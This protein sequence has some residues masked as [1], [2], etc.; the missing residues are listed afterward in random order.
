MEG[1]YH[2]SIFELPACNFKSR[3]PQELRGFDG[4]AFLVAIMLSLKNMQHMEIRAK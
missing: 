1:F 4:K 2:D 3:I